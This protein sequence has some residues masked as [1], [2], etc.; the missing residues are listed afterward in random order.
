VLPA[1]RNSSAIAFH[2]LFFNLI[3]DFNIV[4]A[5]E[6][7]CSRQPDPAT[8]IPTLMSAPFRLTGDVLKLRSG[9]RANKELFKRQVCCQV[10]SYSTSVKYSLA[11]A[12]HLNAI[13]VNI[14]VF[15]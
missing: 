1:R 5:G 10:T 3:M 7:S 8:A 4:F 11:I 2:V 6:A 14:V 12:S 9:G 15:N 13:S